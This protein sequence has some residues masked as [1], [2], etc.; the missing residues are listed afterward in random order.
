MP[1]VLQQCRVGMSTVTLRDL[2]FIKLYCKDL[3]TSQFLQTNDLEFFQREK[4]V[5]IYSVLIVSVFK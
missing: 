1:P 3:E 4:V 2:D 5:S